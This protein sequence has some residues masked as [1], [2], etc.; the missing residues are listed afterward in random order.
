MR[1]L[2]VTNHSYMLWQ[3][4]KELVEQL[5]KKGEVVIATPFVGH[6]KDFKKLGCKC[7]NTPL[8]RRGTNPLHDLQLFVLY[9]RILHYTKPD[10]VITYSI[11]PNV[12]CGWLCSKMHIPYFVNVQ[13][14]GTAFQRRKTFV[15]VSL[16]YKIACANAKKV[17]FEN[18]ENAETFLQYKLIR[19]NQVKINPGAG[20]NLDYYAYKEYPS[21]EDGIRFLYVGR[22]MKEKG[23]WELLEAYSAVKQSHPNVSLDVVGFFEDDETDF[24][25]KMKELGIN[26]HGFKKDPRPYYENSHCV[27]LPSYHEGMSNV[28]LEAASMGRPLIVSNISGC[29]EVINHE[30]NGFLCVEKDTEDLITCMNLFLNESETSHRMMGLE[31]RKQA[32]NVFDKKIVVSRVLEEVEQVT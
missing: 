27:I 5:L 4:R 13:G 1:Y 2:I 7:I 11:K 21:E 24:R 16:M 23:F 10:V 19:P 18:K 31:S 22:I 32:E 26:F 25:E 28:L 17:F 14:L 20:V 8:E 6:E 9:K 29:K 30:R 3:F 12:Y 15:L